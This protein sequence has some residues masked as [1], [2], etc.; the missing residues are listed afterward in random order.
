MAAGA[1]LA[2]GVSGYVYDHYL[3]LL[4]PPTWLLVAALVATENTRAARVLVAGAV[5]GTSLMLSLPGLR[6]TAIGAVDLARKFWADDLKM[7]GPRQIARLIRPQLKAGD[8]IYAVC[9]PIVLYQ[10]LDARPPTRFT[11]YSHHLD[12]RFATALDLDITRELESI[13]RN[14]PAVVVLGDFERCYEIPRRSWIS[15]RQALS[16]NDY[17]LVGRIYGH[18]LYA[19]A[20]K[21][22]SCR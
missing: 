13:F 15:V 10:L 7:D 8:T 16:K 5:A 4:I 18:S 14:Q 19:P 11:F 22:Q 20:A 6:M 9:T 21:P 3:L 17:R 1:A 12:P 2:A